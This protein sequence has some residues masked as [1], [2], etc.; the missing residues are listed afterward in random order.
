MILMVA[1]LRI[2]R[3]YNR[4]S[5]CKSKLYTQDIF[6][7]Y[8]YIYIYIHSDICLE[9]QGSF[10]Q[11]IDRANTRQHTI[12]S[13]LDRDVSISSYRLK[14][15]GQLNSY[16]NICTSSCHSHLRLN[17]LSGTINENLGK[18]SSLMIL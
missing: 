17:F 10:Q 18:L 1:S 8:I 14:Q 2:L 9:N 4:F 12:L 13:K 15:Y 6:W 5:F 11:S 7:F 3:V 16:P